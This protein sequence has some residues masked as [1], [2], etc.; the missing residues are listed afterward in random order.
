MQ[1]TIQPLPS[2]FRDPSGFVF[3][4][5]GV[6]YRQVNNVFSEDFDHFISSGCYEHLTRN[7]WLISHEEIDDLFE[8]DIAC[9]KIL[10]PEKIPFISYP[11]EWSFD[12]LKDAALLTLRLVT[13][14]S[15]Y[16]AMLKDAS[17]ANVQWLNGRPVFID[18][19][20][21][22]KYDPSHP[23]IAYRQFC[24]N[25]V[26]PLLLMHHLQ[27]PM[28]ALLLAWPDGIPLSMVRTMLPWRSKFSF[29]TYLHIHLHARLAS[30][31]TARSA[32]TQ[33]NFSAKKLRRL[34]DS[35]TSL[36]ESLEWR[37]KTSWDNYYAEASQRGHY[38]KLKKNI[39]AAWINEIPGLRKAIDFGANE[40]EFSRLLSTKNMRTIA[41]DFDHSA[42]NKLYQNMKNSAG[43][44]ILPLLVDLANPSPAAGVNNKERLS[45]MERAD[46]D[47]GLGLALVHHLCIGKNIPFEKICELFKCTTNYLVIEFV[48]KGDDKV[49]FMLREK[50][51]IYYNYTE[52]NF[53]DAFT[54]DFSILKREPVGDSGRTI[55]LMKNAAR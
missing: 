29:H 47:I 36:I 22:E 3:E 45:F 53:L 48:P 14:S 46:A 33:V 26:A 38:L 11:Y 42:V 32:L 2:S 19:L 25:F 1:K 8:R 23:W 43:Q 51:D 9:Y 10:K 49:Q 12:M 20:S 55:F 52:E 50:K 16:G 35:L 40:G 39:V 21:F 18:S 37:G 17:P 6:L 13:E 4:R 41:V 7:N 27:Q 34:V 30:K 24:E 44:L 5:D 28:N 31:A 15:A 54:K